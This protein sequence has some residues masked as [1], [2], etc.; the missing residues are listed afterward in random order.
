M[1]GARPYRSTNDLAGIEIGGG[2]GG[3]GTSGGYR[4][5]GALAGERELDVD[6]GMEGSEDDSASLVSSISGEFRSESAVPEVDSGAGGAQGRRDRGGGGSGS[7]VKG[8]PVEVP[9]A[10]AGSAGRRNVFRDGSDD[11]ERKVLIKRMAR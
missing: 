2:G 5:G 6:G 11:S 7:C 9:P 4:N 10:E 1:D 3:T 8:R